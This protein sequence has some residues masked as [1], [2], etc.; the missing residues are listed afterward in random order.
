MTIPKFASNSV[1]FSCI[2]WLWISTSPE[3]MKFIFRCSRQFET[4]IIIWGFQNL[5]CQ[6]VCWCT[7]ELSLCGRKFMA[8]IALHE[9]ALFP[10]YC[11]DSWKMNIVQHQNNSNYVMNS[12]PDSWVYMFG[13][14][15]LMIIRSAWGFVENVLRWL[16]THVNDFSLPGC[17]LCLLL[18]KVQNWFSSSLLDKFQ[19]TPSQKWKSE[20]L[21][22]VSNE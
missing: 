21:N 13:L 7:S 18:C 2:F 17:N 3:Y 9:C 5:D 10:G 4:S 6:V 1:F 12:C 22:F 15:I 11:M 16:D 19:T 20:S 8:Y 14:V